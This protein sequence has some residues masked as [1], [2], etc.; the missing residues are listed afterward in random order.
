MPPTKRLNFAIKLPLYT[1]AIIVDILQIIFDL[2]LAAG[3]VINRI[4][5]IIMAIILFF[6][7]IFLRIMD[8]RTAFY[9]VISF[10]VEEV[11]FLDMAPAW[12]ID[13][14]RTFVRAEAQDEA[15]INA[16]KQQK[17][18]QKR[19]ESALNEPPPV[20]TAPKRPII[21]DINQREAA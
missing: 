9:L 6:S 17:I 8:T 3:V 14:W 20:P 2:T 11:P 10:I 15:K 1:L 21:N 16:Y 4:I 19:Q 7:F 5:D 13:V 18:E 12:S